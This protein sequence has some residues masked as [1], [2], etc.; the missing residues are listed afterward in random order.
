MQYCDK[1]HNGQTKHRGSIEARYKMEKPEKQAI[2]RQTQ[3]R[4]TGDTGSIKTRQSELSNQRHREYCDK[5]Q[6][7]QTRDTAS[8][9]TRHRIDK[10]ETQAILRQ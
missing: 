5:T 10:P 1:S 4:K 7:G 2:L 3:K 6:N 8:I 9:E